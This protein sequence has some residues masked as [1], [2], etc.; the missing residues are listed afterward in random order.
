[1]SIDPD[2]LNQTPIVLDVKPRTE[3]TGSGDQGLEEIQRETQALIEALTRRAQEEAH[4]AGEFT[5]DTYLKV[6]RQARAAVEGTPLLD[7]THLEQSFDSLQQEAEKT[8]GSLQQE[9][10]KNWHA[11][12]SEMNG[13][14]DRLS[15]AA[16]AAWEKLVE[17]DKTPKE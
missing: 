6:I 12:V 15:E 8:I 7:P 14:G 9:A 11:L 3:V 10:E 13:L 16:K 4:S 1:M 17:Q 2:D 5:R